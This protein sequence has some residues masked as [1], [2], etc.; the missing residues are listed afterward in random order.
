[1]FNLLKWLLI[2]VVVGMLGLTAYA[3]LGDMTPTRSPQE[4]PVQLNEPG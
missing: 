3:Y 1:M 2:L 4:L